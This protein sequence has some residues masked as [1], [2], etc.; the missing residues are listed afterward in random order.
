LKVDFFHSNA[1]PS[2]LKP[3]AAPGFPRE[4]EA[5]AEEI[6]DQH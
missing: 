4:E 2:P 3:N 6:Y 1:N 5:A